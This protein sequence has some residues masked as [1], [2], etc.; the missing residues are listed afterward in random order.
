MRYYYV[1]SLTIKLKLLIWCT[2]SH[3]F[4]M[5]LWICW[6]NIWKLDKGFLKN[7]VKK[8][9]TNKKTSAWSHSCTA[10]KRRNRSESKLCQ[11]NFCQAWKLTNFFID[12]PWSGAKCQPRKYD[13]SLIFIHAMW[14]IVFGQQIF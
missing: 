5:T 11:R 7:V 4:D 2:D 1:L 8:T 14:L 10:V 3:Y 13:L 9:Q 6:Y 12:M